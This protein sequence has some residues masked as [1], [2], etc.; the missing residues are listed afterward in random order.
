MPTTRHTRTFV[1]D[2]GETE[3]EVSFE[4][5]PGTPESGAFGPPED[6]DPGSG[7]E[8]W[9]MKATLVGNPATSVDLTQDEADRFETETMED[10]DFEPNPGPSED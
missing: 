10:P 7:P 2:N 4:F 6:Y 1:R 9:D 5:T 8:F 3:V